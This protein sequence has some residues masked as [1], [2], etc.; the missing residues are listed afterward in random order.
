MSSR[1]RVFDS[2]V[3]SK[4]LIGLTGLALFV[5]LIT[6]IIG[7][8]LV[9]LGADIFNLYAHTLTSN[10]LIPVIEILLLLLFLVHIFKTVKMVLRNRNARPEAYV[11]KKRAG[12]P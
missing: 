3:G 11:M 7:N 8:I 10:P 2:T 6:H 12:A 5:Y 4:I 1:L 9:F